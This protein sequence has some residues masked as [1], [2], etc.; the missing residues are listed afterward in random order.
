[1]K[2]H[3]KDS[4]WERLFFF[5]IA[6]SITTIYHATYASIPT[7]DG[8]TWVE[9]I[10]KMKWRF[11]VLPTHLL[12]LF[13]IFHLK[14]SLNALGI[15]ID[16]LHIIQALNA[17]TS[18]MIVM[19]FYKLAR[20]LNFSRV[21]ASC[22]TAT[23]GFSYGL[24][25]FAN[26]EIHHFGIFSIIL[27]FILTIFYCQKPTFKLALLIGILHSLSILLH[28]EHALFFVP[29]SWMMLHERPSK[30]IWG[31]YFVY[32]LSVFLITSASAVF[33]MGHFIFH[34]YNWKELF[35]WFFYIHRNALTTGHVNFR[36]DN[37]NI[38]KLLKGWVMGLHYGAQIL[39][40]YVRYDQ[41]LHIR[42]VS[43]YALTSLLSDE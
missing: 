15:F 25:Y 33:L 29:I 8:F 19:V 20:L 14:I 39:V 42:N 13:L 34:R 43:I 31:F 7:S 24:W 35:D 41:W 40:D 30:K 5:G 18:F 27:L 28:Q 36:W 38:F 12:P 22:A 32:C 4:F 16:T 17:M 26:G 37:Q 6:L 9:A 23:L 10:D 11:I 21:L 3:N 1:M 2:S